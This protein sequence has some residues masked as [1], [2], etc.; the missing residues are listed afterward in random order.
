M[1]CERT[2]YRY[3]LISL[4]VSFH[5]PYFP[6]AVIFLPTP[7]HEVDIYCQIIMLHTYIYWIHTDAMITDA[8]MKDA[9]RKDARIFL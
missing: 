5:N 6:P 2:V 9:G 8:V 4:N 7:L 3:K 1:P